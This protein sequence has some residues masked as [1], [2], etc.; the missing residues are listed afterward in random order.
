[1]PMKISELRLLINEEIQNILSEVKQPNIDKKLIDQY[2]QIKVYSVNGEKVRDLT[3]GD[4][5]FGLSSVHACFPKL[6]PDNEVWIEDDVKKEEI[7]LDVLNLK[8]ISCFLII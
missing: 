2:G 5:E 1:M 6:I 8:F 4:E 7:Q 3:K